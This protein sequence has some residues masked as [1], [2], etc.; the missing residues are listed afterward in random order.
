MPFQFQ[1]PA[2]H[3]LEAEESQ[4]GQHSQCPLCGQTFAIPAPDGLSSGPVANPFQPGPP[5]SGLSQQGFSPEGFSPEGFSPEG[6]P[7]IGPPGS[8]PPAEPAPFVAQQ[9]DVPFDP[10]GAFAGPRMFHIPCPNGHE[11][12]VP[13][14][15]IGQDVMCPHCR[16]QFLLRE[17]DS[18]EAK[19]RRQEELELKEYKAGKTWLMW[20][21]IFAVLVVLGLGVL[22][23]LSTAG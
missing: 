13:P 10:T 15:M 20:A 9:P 5:A 16:V 8:S 21:V 19:R 17:R 11:L 23:A 6:P 7:P 3:L 22:I 2:G 1:C 14:E 4:I 18:V 12:E